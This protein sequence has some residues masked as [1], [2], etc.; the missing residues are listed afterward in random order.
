MSAKNFFNWK[1]PV[2]LWCLI[3]MILTSCPK[4]NVPTGTF[5]YMDKLAHLFIY[6]IL[7]LLVIRALVRDGN[8]LLPGDARKVLYITGG[9]AVFDELH[10]IPIPGRSGDFY[11]VLADILGILL[12]IC[13][14]PLLSRISVKL[15]LAAN[16][17]GDN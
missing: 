7:T 2:L 3:I 6:F 8:K 13:I 15:R 17:R 14:F 1:L 11:D 9:F 12:A 16:S 10:Q 4:L 5:D